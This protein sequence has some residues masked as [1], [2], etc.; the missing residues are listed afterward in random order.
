MR[1]AESGENLS[2]DLDL[3]CL[4]LMIL[5]SLILVTSVF[6][7]T[8]RWILELFKPMMGIIYE[9]NKIKNAR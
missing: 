8:C 2:L 9:E 1:V 4:L 5:F 7:M 6:I 3:T